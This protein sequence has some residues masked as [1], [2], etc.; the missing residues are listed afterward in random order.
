MKNEIILALDQSTQITGWSIFKD[1]ELYNYGKFNP[2]GELMERIIKLRDWVKDTI[3]AEDIAFVGIEDIQLQQIP[4][5]KRDVNV[6]TF[7]KLAY[8]Q[9]ILVELCMDL[10]VEYEIVPSTRWKSYLEIKGAKRT[11]QKRN[12]QQY[13]TEHYGVTPTQDEC[14]AICIGLY[15]TRNKNVLDWT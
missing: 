4:G 8:A 11:E 3:V 1:G 6:A 13:I 5:T 12:A 9:A 14:D 15:L 10:G 2:S 7:K